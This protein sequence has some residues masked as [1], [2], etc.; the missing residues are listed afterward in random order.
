MKYKNIIILIILALIFTAC[1]PKESNQVKPLE[2]IQREYQNEDQTENDNYTEV[3]VANNSTSDDVNDTENTEATVEDTEAEAAAEEEEEAEAEAEEEAAAEEIISEYQILDLIE[4]E[5]I[6]EYTTGLVFIVKEDDLWRV[7]DRLGKVYR[8]SSSYEVK[9]GIVNNG[10]T[11]SVD[12]DGNPSVSL[13]RDYTS[14]EN[15]YLMTMTKENIPKEFSKTLLETQKDIIGPSNIVD[16]KLNSYEVVETY[17][18][19]IIIIKMNFDVKPNPDLLTSI[20]GELNNEGIAENIDYIYT[21]YGYDSTWILPVKEPL[22]NQIQIEV[23]LSQDDL[24]N[25]MDNNDD[26]FALMELQTQLANINGNIV[27]FEKVLLPQ[28][29]ALQGSDI[30]EHNVYLKISQNGEV[31]NIQKG[32][33]N[34]IYESITTFGTKVYLFNIM[35]LL[36]SGEIYNGLSMIDTGNNSYRTIYIGNIAKG[37]IVNDKY[38]VFGNDNLFEINLENSSLRIVSV[39]PEHLEFGSD[40]AEIKSIENGI[41]KLEIFYENELNSYQ[42]NILEGN[43]ELVDN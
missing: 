33:Q 13:I 35:Q 11:V 26:E 31:T 7:V 42:V 24:E 1:F 23:D 38:Y 6:T 12:E 27:F 39:L 36:P 25:Q 4:P 32:E 15:S 40:T 21:L 22:Y 19:G 30:Y 41:M 9:P 28:S 2:N 3:E 43:M 34:G 29:N 18:K 5:D 8:V 14:Y 16:Y 10:A 37:M 17:G 20:W